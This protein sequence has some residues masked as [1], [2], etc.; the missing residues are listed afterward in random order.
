MLTIEKL[1]EMAEGTFATGVATDNPEGIN[2]ANTNKD[3]RW[4]AV[5]GGIHDWAIYCH[6]ADKSV[7][8][9]EKHGDKVN[10]ES[11][12]RKLVECD[13]EAFNMYRY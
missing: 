2:M 1:K 10:R 12:I 6:W 5:R 8:W 9:I 4:V 13:D 3:L 11:H 7:R